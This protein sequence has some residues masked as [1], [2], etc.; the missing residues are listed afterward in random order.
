METLQVKGLSELGEALV[1]FGNKLAFKYL[2][3]ATSDAAAVFRDEA[4][5]RAPVLTGAMRDAIAI[6]KR[7]NPTPTS[8][9]Y[10]VG[11]GKLRIA[12]RIQRLLRRA[13]AADPHVINAG[14]CS[15]I[16]ATWNSALRR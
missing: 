6:F 13:H 7:K 8:V 5:A 9:M 14:D 11:V 10:A 15:S 12:K 3:A 2:R 4:K 1:E 16:G